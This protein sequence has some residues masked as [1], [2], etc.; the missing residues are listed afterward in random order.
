MTEGAGTREGVFLKATIALLAC[1]VV[2]VHFVC[3]PS[4][5]QRWGNTW[6]LSRWD[7]LD[8][9]PTTDW[10]IQRRTQHP[11]VGSAQLRGQGHFMFTVPTSGAQGRVR[12]KARLPHEQR[13]H[14]QLNGHEVA[15]LEP[16]SS[17]PIQRWRFLVSP[18]HL[19]E[20][21]NVLTLTNPD[22]DRPIEVEKI[23]VGNVLRERLPMKG[24][25]VIDQPGSNP[26]SWHPVLVFA[27]LLSSGLIALFLLIAPATLQL[28]MSLHW[29]NLAPPSALLLG[30]TGLAAY[31]TF[32]P[33][34]VYMSPHPLGE[35]WIKSWCLGAGITAGC[36]LI[37]TLIRF[38]KRDLRFAIDPLVRTATSSWAVTTRVWTVLVTATVRLGAIVQHLLQQRWLR[39]AAL[40]G[41]CVLALAEGSA[42]YMQHTSD[43]LAAIRTDSDAQVYLES[44]VHVAQRHPFLIGLFRPPYFPDLL[45]VWNT[46]VVIAT[47]MGGFIHAWGF[48]PGVLY[49]GWTMVVLGGVFCL[50][51]Y[52]WQRL[53]GYPG[54]GGLAA[55]FLLATSLV[56][57]QE[58][59][60]P[61]T[62]FLGMLILGGTFLL[63]ARLAIR[64]RWRDVVITSIGMT[65]LALSRTAN[66]YTGVVL[67]TALAV[68]WVLWAPDRRRRLTRLG[69][70]TALIGLVILWLTILEVTLLA[71]LL[72]TSYLWRLVQVQIAWGVQNPIHSTEP[73]KVMFGNLATP[74][75]AMSRDHLAWLVLIPFS[76][77]FS[78]WCLC[79]RHRT[80]A[81]PCLLV[82]LPWLAYLAIVMPGTPN[83]RYALPWLLMEGLLAAQLLDVAWAAFRRVLTTSFAW[84]LTI[85][86][87]LAIGWLPIATTSK[88]LITQWREFSMS[89]TQSRRYLAEV[90]QQLPPTAV[91]LVTFRVDPWEV[92]RRLQRPTAYAGASC[93]YGLLVNPRDLKK[94]PYA[95]IDDPHDALRTAGLFAHQTARYIERRLAA[96]QTVWFLD[97]VADPDAVPFFHSAVGGHTG[98]I[99]A[100]QYTVHSISLEP[101]REGWKLYQIVRARRP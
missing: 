80:H 4:T 33:Y 59:A 46:Q 57:R 18:D 37:Q 100:G 45:A 81:L 31:N 84:G 90:A 78:F 30:L 87:V 85:L 82:F 83:V 43:M 9:L 54:L 29:W 10:A 48:Y 55:G 88:E 27:G 94:H 58:L 67:L 77:A 41:L 17:D 101:H 93:D 1:W 21:E 52:V 3:L 53:W 50:V 11:T 25:L 76:V 70:F 32:T 36:A 26:V 86:G 89:R 34:A 49:W 74:A 62:D 79:A 64:E 99:P 44:A 75:V 12:V 39:P 97:L 66:L 22:S 8:T 15:T 23:T 73:F 28:P 71:R 68:G 24:V 56:T 72:H 42:Y 92:A 96:G 38:R 35:L 6:D 19:Q 95:F 65:V 2:V 61:A 40:G 63:V 20:G 51:P 7:L 13:L 69:K 60:R 91:V 16:V 98:F 47:A 14:L 5:F